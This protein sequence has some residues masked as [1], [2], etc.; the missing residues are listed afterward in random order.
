MKL[1]VCGSR[2]W[3]DKERLENEIVRLHNHS[4]ITELICGDAKGADAYAANIA[5][6]HDIPC[7]IFYADW[8]KHGKAAGIVRNKAMLNQ[9]PDIVLACWDGQS[10]GTKN[11]IDIANKASITILILMDTPDPCEGI[12]S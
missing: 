3:E 2:T 12:I 8:N 1:L 7:R 11:M 5:I 9:Q 10:K 6:N 4:K